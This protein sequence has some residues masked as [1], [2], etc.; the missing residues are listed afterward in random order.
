[1][2]EYAK[3]ADIGIIADAVG[4]PFPSPLGA[5]FEQSSAEAIT[6]AAFP[7][8]QTELYFYGAIPGADWGEATISGLA[9]Q[10]Y[11]F[12]DT[13]AFQY[14]ANWLAMISII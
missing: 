1:M 12:A 10:L 3:I 13:R 11:Q 2:P 6:A 4:L 9:F 7:V 5:F 8:D 14:G